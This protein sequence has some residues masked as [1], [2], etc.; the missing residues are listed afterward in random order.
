MSVPCF[1]AGGRLLSRGVAYGECSDLENLVDGQTE[2]VQTAAVVDVEGLREGG[3][4]ELTRQSQRVLSR[5]G[6]IYSNVHF[7]RQS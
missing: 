5:R 4:K 3:V 1:F 7:P 2:C 6:R